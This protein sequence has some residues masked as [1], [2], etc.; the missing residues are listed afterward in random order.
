MAH[1]RLTV[2]VLV[3]N[4]NQAELLPRQLDSV[5]G[6]TRSA[7]EILVLDDGS[8]DDSVEI[9]ARY[10]GKHPHLRLLRNEVNRGLGFSM[11]R[12]LE[13]AR[14]DFLVS[15]AA[16]DMLLPQF[17]EKS[18]AAL[19]RYPQAGMCISEFVTSETDGTIVNRS[20]QMPA[21]FGVAGLPAYVPPDELRQRFRDRYL[22]MS[23]NTVV[24]R[25]SAVQAAGGFLPELEWH[26]DWFVFYAVALRH[27]T[28]VVPEGLAVIRVNPGGYSDLG[29]KDPTRQRRVL[30]AIADTLKAPRNRGLLP[31]FRRY[32]AL[33]SVF[34][35]EMVLALRTTPRHWDL[36]IVYAAYLAKRYYRNHGPY[37]RAVVR[38]EVLRR[39]RECA[40]QMAPEFARRGIRYYRTHGPHW[41]VVLRYE[42]PS[43]LRQTAREI[44]PEFVKSGIRRLRR[45]WNPLSRSSAADR[46]AALR[47][48]AAGGHLRT[49]RYLHQ[50]GCDLR[51][52]NDAALRL[53]AAGG[54]LRTIRYLHQNGCDLR[55][56][57]DA[58]LRRAAAGGHLETVRYLHQNGCDLRADNNAAL[59]LAEANGHLE[60]VRYLRQS[61][62]A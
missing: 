47:L 33:L 12:L 62:A 49:I 57:N 48:A 5:C 39:L 58:A 18:M 1:P 13:E 22:W 16:D 6:Q 50:N 17:L 11:N 59:R 60:T 25:R 32:P 40:R 23:S 29:M 37:W 44:T 45:A 55:A 24:A 2:S 56:D 35:R 21:S 28:C 26:A 61:G 14:C 30:R 46:G 4:Y 20:R 27:G 10:E 15:A 43:R 38:H 42:V 52:D 41:R 9:I 36:L 7:D 19:E 54:H 3:P 51:A 8:T 31:V 34:G 53:A